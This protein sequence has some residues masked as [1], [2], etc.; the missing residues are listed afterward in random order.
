MITGDFNLHLDVLG[1]LLFILYTTPLSSLISASSV[2]HHLYADDTKLFIF[3]STANF[4]NNI[5]YLE[6]TISKVSSWVVPSLSLNP[7]KT[8]F[9]LIGLPAQLTDIS[10]P[11]LHVAFDTSVS[12]IPSAR[13]LGVIFDYN[14]SMSDHISAI[15]KTTLSQIRD[16]RRIRGC[17]DFTTTLS[18]TT[19]L[20]HSRLRLFSSMFLNLN[21]IAFNLC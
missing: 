4:K 8:E 16:I 10:E 13:N 5:R 9:L 3:L 6:D 7:S 17:L 15:C 12:S 19:S 1:P 11:V 21:L 18:I 20:I 14:M 2:N